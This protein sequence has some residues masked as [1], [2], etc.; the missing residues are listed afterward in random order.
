MLA[1][2]PKNRYAT[3]D[4]LIADLES[5]R[6]HHTSD[7]VTV[8]ATTATVSVA[9]TTISPPAGVRGAGA[10][11]V[12]IHPPDMAERPRRPPLSPVVKGVA[13]AAIGLTLL[14]LIF[15][16]RREPSGEIVV[17][18][19]RN[20][21]RFR[22]VRDGKTV[23]G[24]TDR[25]SFTLPPGP[26]VVEAEETIG[27]PRFAPVAVTVKPGVREPVGFHLPAPVSPPTPVPSSTPE[28]RSGAAA[29]PAP[30]AP[31]RNPRSFRHG[32]GPVLAVAVSADGRRAVTSGG[33]KALRVWGLPN[34]DPLG[35]MATEGPVFAVAITAD[36]RRAVSTAGPR[37][38]GVWDLDARRSIDVLKGHEHHINAIA[39]SPDG[40]IALSGAE[41]ATAR[42]WDLSTQ[43]PI[44]VL[45]HEGRVNAVA[46]SSDGRL[47]LTGSDD[48][49]IRIWPRDD[50]AKQV[51]Q[52]DAGGKV[53][54]LALSNDGR[55]LLSGCDNG[56]VKLWDL[57]ARTLLETL[58]GG[59]RDYV[60]A[61][62]FLPDGTRALTVYR[63]GML[64]LW[65]LATVTI[66]PV[67]NASGE[68]H[69]GL[70]L[71]PDGRHALTADDDGMVRA[72]R[73]PSHD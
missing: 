50:M 16:R 8:P 13:T 44:A 7:H 24:P 68:D 64:L 58:T 14:A 66:T 60:R 28:T 26:Y 41:D 29:R 36:G 54:C 23:V 69:L 5:I 22:I 12:V 72:W 39:L 62:V 1:K 10:E 20:N 59:P 37:N 19:D 3:V 32:A 15:D 63:N 18:C 2:A 42:L 71:L 38:L 11:T 31:P 4:A 30:P 48:G 57:D 35:A 27:G 17:Q 51:T 43:K 45:A 53:F 34:G 21:Q 55:R 33:D 52:L 49:T 73:L 61:A 70:A 65:N 46:L 9:P 67:S 25:R 56:V 6:S 40:R 47:A